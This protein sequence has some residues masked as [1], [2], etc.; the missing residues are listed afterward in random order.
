MVAIFTGLYYHESTLMHIQVFNH[1]T[2]DKARLALNV[3]VI[4]EIC[5]GWDDN[6]NEENGIYI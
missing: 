6:K 2:H 1:K 4:N 5:E 3:A